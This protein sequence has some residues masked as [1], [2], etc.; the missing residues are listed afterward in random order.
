MADTVCCFPHPQNLVAGFAARIGCIGK[1]KDYGRQWDLFSSGW[2]ARESNACPTGAMPSLAAYVARQAMGPASFL[3]EIEL[4]RGEMDSGTLVPFDD[5][6]VSIR[7]T[8]EAAGYDAQYWLQE[9]ATPRKFESPLAAAA[10]LLASR[11]AYASHRAMNT[12]KETHSLPHTPRKRDRGR[13]TLDDFAVEV[14]KRP[15][16][17][18]ETDAKYWGLALTRASDSQRQAF[19]IT[20]GALESSRTDTKR[21]ARGV[22]RETIDTGNQGKADGGAHELDLLE[23]RPRPRLAHAPPTPA[24]HAMPRLARP[25]RPRV[26]D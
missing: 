23:P 9:Q 12:L 10:A 13:E 25:P 18:S 16:L 2:V 4:R 24:R 7:S 26:A 5:V 19:D 1:A 21:L 3:D 11:G 6:P 14:L 22:S 15:K 17:A 8:L 20:Y